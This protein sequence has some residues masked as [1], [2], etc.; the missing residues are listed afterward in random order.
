M[1]DNNFPPELVEAQRGLIEAQTGKTNFESQM[2]QIDLRKAVEGE[3]ERHSQAIFNRIVNFFG[4][5]DIR[6]VDSAITAIEYFARRD[7]GQPQTINLYTPGGDIVAGLALYDT[8]Q[9][10]RRQGVH[11]TTRAVGMAASMGAV[12]LQAGD[13][14]VMDARAK[15]LI[16]EGSSML[17]GTPGEVEDQQLLWK[18]LRSDVFDILA[19]RATVSRTAL[20]NKAKRKDLW[21][22]ANEALKLGLVDRVE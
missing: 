1:T 14:R 7:P 13:D 5:V 22:D 18:M 2:A 16:H 3:N 11:F 20:V 19:E 9:R 8:I 17:G 15:L 21:L 10:L 12:L 6:N 4:P